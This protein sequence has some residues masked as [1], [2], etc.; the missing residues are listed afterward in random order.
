M[1]LFSR[2]GIGTVQ[3]GMHYGISNVLGQTSASEVSSILAYAK[4]RGIHL[5]DTALAYGDAERTLGENNLSSFQVVS[6]F[7]ALNPGESLM[8]QLKVSLASLKISSLYGYL[9]HRSKDLIERPKC[10]DDLQ[11]AKEKGLAIKIG[12]SL[13]ELE[14]FELLY[15]KGIRPDLIQVPFNF[16]DRRFE[17]VMKQ[18]KSDGCE[19]HSRSVFLQGLFFSPVEHLPSFF[20]EVK[21]VIAQLQAQ[22]TNLASSLIHFVMSQ[23]FIDKVIMGVN[24][25]DQLKNNLEQ[26]DS[27]EA[28][29][30]EA[31]KVSDNILIPSRWP[32]N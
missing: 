20:D 1:S 21:P 5:I 14:D 8:D 31:F 17:A 15:S 32:K 6:K 24:N 12:F 7:R 3:F 29:S 16:L 11:Q 28:L 26:L 30:A 22:N 25:V 13:N 27:T 10:W 2:L 4:S 18:C 19:V 23:P 9:A